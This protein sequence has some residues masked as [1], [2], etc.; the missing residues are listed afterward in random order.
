MGH[1]LEGKRAFEGVI[2]HTCLYLRSLIVKAAKYMRSMSVEGHVGG[3]D[4]ET[5]CKL[6]TEEHS[7]QSG[8][9]F[10][11]QGDMT[12]PNRANTSA[13]CPEC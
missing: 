7:G 11:S 2:E 1:R 10:W 5:V 9:S 12:L 3:T 13:S 6:Q 8:H 4:I